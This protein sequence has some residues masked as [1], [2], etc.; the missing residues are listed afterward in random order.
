MAE[1]KKE[2]V[3]KTVKKT[4]A[5]KEAETEAKVEEVVEEKKAPAK[6]TTKKAE[7]K[8]EPKASLPAPTRHDYDVI[9]APIITEKSMAELQNANKVTVKVNANANKTEIK[10]AFEHLYQ[11][12]VDKVHIT[13]VRAKSTTRGSRYLG[14][15]SGYKKAVLTI[16]EGSAIDLFKE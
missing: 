4:S 3:K 16:H 10:H 12:K 2:T 15:I 14:K 1:E 8:E 6:K 7:K 9:Y 11:V 13:N 5:K